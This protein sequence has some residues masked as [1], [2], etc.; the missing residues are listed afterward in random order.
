MRPKSD[1]LVVGGG[2]IGVSVAV[3]LQIRGV[4]VAL[5]DWERPGAGTSY[6]NAGLIQDEAIMPYL[7]PRSF[8]ELFRYARNRSIDASYDLA[9]LPR[10]SVPFFRYWRNSRADRALAIARH[11]APLI[12][13]SIADHLELANMAGAA[14]LLRPTGWSKLFY[15]QR[16]LDQAVEEAEA[17]SREL[18]VSYVAMD[19]AGVAGQ[20]PDLSSMVAGGLHWPS[21]LSVS[22]P[23][24]LTKA[25]LDLFLGL[26]GVLHKGDAQLL[27]SVSDGWQM[28]TEQGLAA[29]RRVV[30]SL[31]PWSPI[32]YEKFGYSL[33]FFVMRGYHRHYGVRGGARLNRPVLDAENGYF[34]VPM[35]QGIRLTT[36]AEFARRNAPPN[37]VQLERALPKAR[38]LF[39]AL[40]DALES[41]PWVGARP[42]MPDMLPVIGPAPRHPGMWFALGHGHHGLTMGPTTGK[43][44]AD[45]ITGAV[46]F[47]DPAP[48]RADRFQ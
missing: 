41:E 42:C 39:P 3:Q 12:S 36:G 30:I 14:E 45:L 40:G 34:L 22:D 5:V 46:P 2:I 44:M 29:A 21:P 13:R 7:F 11:R 18:G 23:Y 20:E 25:Y 35:R 26:G 32:L 43:L 17:Q 48:Y 16:R 27:E 6:G 24:A 37:P 33:P 15:S 28:P 9:A 38:Q 1:I 47:T 8:G 4:K 31:G 19:G 10:L